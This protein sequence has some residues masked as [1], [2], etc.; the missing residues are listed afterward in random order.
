MFSF[1]AS[2]S[3]RHTEAASGLPSTDGKDQE[4]EREGAVEARDR[5]SGT[6]GR[7]GG[8]PVPEVDSNEINDQPGLIPIRDQL[9]FYN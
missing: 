4:E 2:L 6:G 8:Q 5:A 3:Q 9:H 1:S 7:P